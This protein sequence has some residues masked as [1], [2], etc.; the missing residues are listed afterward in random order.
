MPAASSSTLHKLISVRRA[1]RAGGSTQSTSGT[2]TTTVKTLSRKI[3]PHQKCSTSAPPTTAPNGVAKATPAAQI[4]NARTRS[5]SRNR[6]PMKAMPIGS[7]TEAPTAITTRMEI[8]TPT[9]GANAVAAEAA[10]N[11][12]RPAS[13]VRRYPQ[14]LPNAGTSSMNEAEVMP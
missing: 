11:S 6:M 12:S 1:A 14:R 9:L 13:S 5:S 10:P 2:T 7:T 8:S 4:P 3:Q